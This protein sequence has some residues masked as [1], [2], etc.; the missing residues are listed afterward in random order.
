MKITLVCVLLLAA[1]AWGAEQAVIN[2]YATPEEAQNATLVTH[3]P[4]LDGALPMVSYAGFAQ[5]DAKYDSN[6]FYWFFEA[7][8]KA[9]DA[10]TEKDIP[11]VI[12]VRVLFTFHTH[13]HTHAYSYIIRTRSIYPFD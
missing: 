8:D 3:L 7:A 11:F 2:R 6:L 9:S 5:V 4:G 12:W 13:T 1:A 10:A